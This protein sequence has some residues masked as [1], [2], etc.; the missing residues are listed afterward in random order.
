M[1]QVA[2]TQSSYDVAG[3]RE[4]LSDIIFDVSPTETPLLSAIK[5]V[6][7]KGTYHEWQTDSLTA[8][9]AT[10]AAIEGDEAS[11]S[12]PTA[13]TRLGN[14]TQILTK[15]AI[16]TGT[17]ES[18]DKAGRSSEMAY[19]IE[20]RMKEIK[21]DAE[22]SMFGAA[23][24][25][26]PKVAGNDT[27]A[28]EMGSIETYMTSNVSFGTGGAVATGDGSDAMTAGTDRA[29]SETLLTTVLESC[30]DNGGNP[31]ILAVSATN[32]GVVSGF[33]GS[34]QTRYVNSD[35]KTLRTAIDVYEGDFHKLKVVACRQLVGDNVFCIDPEYLACA[36]LRPAFTEDLA[37]TGDAW[38][39][40]IIWETT[41]EVCNEAAHGLIADTNG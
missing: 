12:T 10:N 2:G 18:V 27:T 22:A 16:V 40:Q 14:Y 41:L 11:F 4:D 39:K 17:Q 30:F 31:S 33:A 21:R 25:G 38:K 35:D 8:A 32:K 28:R 23:V 29:F 34:G 37:K 3:N 1:A 5:K 7:A 24:I 9:S 36:D 15:N 13:T 6:K 20:R 26:N 19:Q